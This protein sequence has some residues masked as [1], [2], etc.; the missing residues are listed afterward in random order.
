MLEHHSIL[1]W[2]QE[3]H[4]SLKLTVDPYRNGFTDYLYYEYNKN[5]NAVIHITFTSPTDLAIY[6]EWQDIEIRE[7][8]NMKILDVKSETT[9]I[10]IDSPNLFDK[11]E[12]AITWRPQLKLTQS[13]AGS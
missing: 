8:E 12:K 9:I 5:H 13:S 10:Q 7:K 1:K 2:I 6:H 3:N 4:P 11:I